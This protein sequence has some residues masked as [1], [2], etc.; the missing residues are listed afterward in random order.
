LAAAALVARAQ[1]DTATAIAYVEELEMCTREAPDSS[2]LQYALP[3]LRLCID[4]DHLELG[5]RLFNRPAAGG[6]RQETVLTAG[7]A[8]IAEARGDVDEAGMLYIEAIR[9]LEEY[10]MPF[11]LGHALL[12]HWRCTGD[13]ESLRSAQ[14]IFRR[15]GAVVPEAEAPAARESTG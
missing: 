8:A 10:D 4:L 12:G 7:K 14:E 6:A 3:M 15:L 5:E 9:S 2:R 1:G 11:E 13:D